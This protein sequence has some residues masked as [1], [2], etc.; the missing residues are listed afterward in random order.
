[1]QAN[2]DTNDVSLSRQ[3]EI[4]TT[5]SDDQPETVMT[6]SQ[7]NRLHSVIGKNVFLKGGISG[8]ENISID[9][10]VEGDIALKTNEV[11]IGAHGHLHANVFAET[12][13]V[14]GEI[15]GDLYASKHV[16][17]KKT[18]RVKG[19]IYTA[20]I[21]IE[22]GANIKGN[23]DM[24]KQDGFKQALPESHEHNYARI[25]G[26]GFLF[27]KNKEAG[28][29]DVEVTQDLL[30]SVHAAESQSSDVD[31]AAF[32]EGKSIIG[33]SIIIKGELFAKEDVVIQGKLE[34]IYY[35]NNSLGLGPRSHVKG[36]VFVKSLISYGDVEGDIYASDHVVIN[37]SGQVYGNIHAPRFSTK[38]G[39]II[40]SQINVEAQNIEE[41]FTKIAGNIS[42]DHVCHQ[43]EN[44]ITPAAAKKT[45][46][47]NKKKTETH[48]EKAADADPF[49]GDKDKNPPFPIFYPRS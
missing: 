21:T 15:I 6:V 11:T 4:K 43:E 25:A 7:Q 3:T 22:D 31:D 33:E 47:S 2:N 49:D 27:K 29:D 18:G 5:H 14:N 13:V 37:S 28:A 38:Q 12:I 19:N 42:A 32:Y 35:A 39:A 17:V 10:C 20:D 40:M 44:K 34:G 48:A 24:E 1:M 26:L 9:G 16:I 36:N 41:R 23:V 45:S 8:C 46:V 30:A